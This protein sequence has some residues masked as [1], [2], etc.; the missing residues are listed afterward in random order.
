MINFKNDYSSIGHI[1]ILKR[2]IEIEEK[3]ETFIGYGMDEVCERARK[4]ILKEVGNKKSKVHLGLLHQ[5]QR[6][7]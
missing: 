4:L 2:M 5:N 6:N 7:I 1:D 3:K